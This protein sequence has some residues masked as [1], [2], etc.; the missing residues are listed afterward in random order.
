MR[1]KSSLHVAT[2]ELE[3]WFET[4]SG[5][6]LDLHPGDSLNMGLTV[7]EWRLT[8]IIDNDDLSV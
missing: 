4:T 2:G 7:V 3:L 5:T 8:K 6:V 1:D